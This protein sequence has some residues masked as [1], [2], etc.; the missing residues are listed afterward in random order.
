MAKQH[1]SARAFIR[2]RPIRVAYLLDDNDYAHLTLDGIFA[3]SIAQWG[4]RYSLICPC[5]CGYPRAS[6]L[7]WLTAFDP[8]IIYSFIDLSDKN[9]QIIRETFGPAYLVRHHNDFKDEIIARD[10]RVRLP[11]APLTALSS[12]L[13]YT[14]AFPASAPQPVRIVDYLPGQPHDPFI[15]DNFG[16]F[17]GSYGRWPIPQNLADAVKPIAVASEELLNS[18]N[19]G[20]RYDGETVPDAAGLLRFMAANGNT[21]GLTQIAAD[22]APHMEINGSYD[23]AFSLIVGDTFADRVVFWNLRSRVPAFIGREP[24]TLIVSPARLENVD[25]V[26]SLSEF[27]QK[28]NGVP[29]NSGPPWVRLCSTSVTTEQLTA[30]RERLTRI[31]KWSGYE[32]APPMTIDSI[33]PSENALR[34][35]HHLVSGGFF[36]G[37]PDWKEFSATGE[38][39]Q[40]P[41]AVPKH[42]SHVQGRN[43]ATTGSWG[44][45]V[46][47]ERQENHSHYSNIRHLWFFPRRLRFHQAFLP[48]YEA[49]YEGREYRHT[50][51]TTKGSLSLFA[52]FGE[53]LPAINLPSDETVFRYAMQRGDTWPPFRRED[54]WQ[55]PHG[56]FAWVQPSDKG[57]YLIGALRMFDGMRPRYCCMI[58]G[59]R[60]S[61]NWVVQSAPRD[62]TK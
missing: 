5:E 13:Q 56:P 32:V 41:A 9:L 38:K 15:D 3:Q 59:A 30:V 23:K 48:Y 27:L 16:T 52:G 19:R 39:T 24:T 40:P 36:E 51:A 28:R 11:I 62:D 12:T 31:D 20:R 17:Y 46:A 33:A 53:E 22:A 4:G 14:R 10:F 43:Y 47:I 44:L 1:E 37:T 42:I 58:I 61:R 8:D 60:C 55:N 34:H 2:A 25:F 54:S 7:P 45:D 35:A 57:R 6:Y 50:R 49:K 21:Y 29:H 26:A 18:P